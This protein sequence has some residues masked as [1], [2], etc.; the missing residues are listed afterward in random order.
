MKKLEKE[1]HA[2]IEPFRV[3]DG[4]RFRLADHDPSGTGGLA[5]PTKD[6]T[7]A[8]MDEALELLR[9]LQQKLFA[10]DRWALLLIFQGID[11]SGKDGTIRHVMSGVDPQGCQVFSFKQPTSLEL[12][13]DFLWRCAV[14]LPERGRIGIFNRSHYEEVAVVRVHRELLAA[15]KLPP[16]LVDGDVW[17]QRFE[18]IRDFERHLGRNGTV[19]RKFFLNLSREEQ[20]RRF[21]ARLDEPE[22]HWKFQAGDVAERA[23]WDAYMEAYESAIRHTATK[24]AP[25]F[26]VPAD[27]KPFARLVVVRAIVDALLDLDLDWPRVTV[28]Q[29]VELE[30]ARARLL[31][32]EEG[33]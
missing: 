9:Q 1:L 16:E 8:R 23:H 27:D 26:V 5:R 6:E 28:K 18:S 17:K 32:E 29:R 20:R 30:A 3:A 33:A 14:A 10:Q 11:A 15:Q 19:V 7:R 2:S 31:A 4:K 24:A 25:W 22:K 21:L 13:H 12:D